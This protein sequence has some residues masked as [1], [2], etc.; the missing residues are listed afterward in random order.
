M[1]A[2]TLL[3]GHATMTRPRYEAR[4][5]SRQYG[6]YWYVRQYADGSYEAYAHGAEG[7]ATDKDVACFYCGKEVAL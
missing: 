7:H 5:Y 2:T 3:R 6:C 1:T 4:R